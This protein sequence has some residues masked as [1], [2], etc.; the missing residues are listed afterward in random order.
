[1]TEPTQPTDPTLHAA[2]QRWR[3]QVIAGTPALAELG[4]WADRADKVAVV[5]RLATIDVD[6]TVTAGA[7]G[8]DA[9]V[10]VAAGLIP[11][12]AALV[13][14]RLHANYDAA[15]LTQVADETVVW[16][17]GSATT[18]WLAA[19]SVCDEARSTPETFAAQVA[20]F[21]VLAADPAARLAAAQ[22]TFA[23]MCAAYTP[24]IDD[25]GTPSRTVAEV[26]RDGGA[27]GAYIAGFDV[28]VRWAENYGLFFVGT[29]RPT[30]GV[31]LDT[32][33]WEDPDRDGH[34]GRSGPVGGSAAYVKAASPAELT[35]ILDSIDLDT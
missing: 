34:R 22:A 1:M 32:F 15:T 24:R 18:W 28:T 35:R 21:Q 5:D 3:R 13:A 16:D 4:G 30:L 7:G 26:L 27:Q 31:N 33:N 17:P 19:C 23:D 2:H 6:G 9:G 29:W 10:A 8:F 25:D 12:E 11:T 20:T 14:A